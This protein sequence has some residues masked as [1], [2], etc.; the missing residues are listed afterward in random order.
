MV[1]RYLSHTMPDANQLVRVLESIKA[2]RRLPETPFTNLKVAARG[3]QSVYSMF[4]QSSSGGSTEGD[5]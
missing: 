1:G 4:K 2:G 3:E 5:S